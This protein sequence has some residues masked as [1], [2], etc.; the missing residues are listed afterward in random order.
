[1]ILGN[2]SITYSVYDRTDGWP[3]PVGETTSYKRP[4]LEF[5][6]DTLSGAG[7]L[8]EIDMPTLSQLAAMEVELSLKKTNEDAIALFAPGTHELE[9]RWINDAIDT[10]GAKVIRSVNKDIIKCV[11]M[12]MDLGKVET[13]ATN[14]ASL[15]AQVLYFQY[16][17]AG[18]T[19]VEIDR[20]NN[21]FKI[22]G[23]DYMA[24]LR[25]AL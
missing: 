19:M 1:M 12:S 10:A 25:D 13:N 21:V 14:D 2:K 5:L 6:S 23:V 11:P 9:I 7:I 15:K 8:G 18:V 4:S 3:K 17:Q 20:L 16:L 22:G 24:E